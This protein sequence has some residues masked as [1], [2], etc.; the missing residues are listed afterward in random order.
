MKPILCGQESS[1]RAAEINI[2]SLL[3][4]NTELILLHSLN[5]SLQVN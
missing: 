1:R 2:V 5:K 3:N 4:V